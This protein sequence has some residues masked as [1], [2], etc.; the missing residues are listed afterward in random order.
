[1]KTIAGPLLDPPANSHGSHPKPLAGRGKCL[2]E[3]EGL[4]RVNFQDPFRG[5]GV[6]STCVDLPSHS[7]PTIG[8]SERRSYLFE[9][10]SEW[11]CRSPNNQQKDSGKRTQYRSRHPLRESACL[12]VR[13]TSWKG[14]ICLLPEPRTPNLLAS[15][16]RPSGSSPQIRCSDLS[17]SREWPGEKP[18]EWTRETGGF[19][20]VQCAFPQNKTQT[21]IGRNKEGNGYHCSRVSCMESKPCEV[22]PDVCLSVKCK[23]NQTYQEKSRQN[24]MAAGCP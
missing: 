13:R 18:G 19:Q 4:W 14:P 16:S 24:T 1:M 5:N 7:S 6:F 22:R 8:R 9:G 10:I 12:L 15:T 11:E 20:R 2:A 17:R 23:L 21:G 3:P